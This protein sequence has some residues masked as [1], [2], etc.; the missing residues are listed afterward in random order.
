MNGEYL[1]SD[2]IATQMVLEPGQP[3]AREL[4]K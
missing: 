3:T 2:H 4:A 1:S